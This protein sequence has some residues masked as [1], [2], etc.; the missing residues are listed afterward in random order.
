VGLWFGHPVRPDRITAAGITVAAVGEAVKRVVDHAPAFD[1]GAGT[2]EGLGV[3]QGEN[4]SDA[5]PCR[6][7]WPER[8]RSWATGRVDSCGLGTGRMM[9]PVSGDRTAIYARLFHE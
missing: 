7:G 9:W 8:L 1:G 6:G 3:A 5:A 2:N 4:G